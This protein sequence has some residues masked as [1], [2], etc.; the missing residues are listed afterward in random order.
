[1]T[2]PGIGDARPAGTTGT[3]GPNITPEQQAQIDE[4][5]NQ[6]VVKPQS[7][8]VNQ[9][10]PTGWRKKERVE[11]DLETPSGQLCRV[12]RFDRND[13][14]RLNLTDYLDTFTPLLLTDDMEPE[15]QQKR[16]MAVAESGAAMGKMFGAIDKVVMSATVRPQITDDASLVN[17]GTEED[18]ANPE[19]VAIVHIDDVAMEDKMYIFGMAFGRSME[20]L[21]SV[22]GEAPSMGDIPAQQNIP[23]LTQRAM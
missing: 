17:Y 20:E 19:F 6:N 15:E 8:A 18:W 2:V 23:D 1:M 3:I 4:I 12:M 11:F 10:A 16:I 13:L 7:K 5:L 22:L 21:K 14:F 9:Y